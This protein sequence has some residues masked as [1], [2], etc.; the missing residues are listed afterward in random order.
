MPRI[1]VAVPV[2]NGASLLSEALANLQ[3]QTHRDFE[4]VV[5]DNASTD[6]TAEIA[7]RAAASDKRVR[8]ERR[9]TLVP[10]IENFKRALESADCDFFA[11]R[12]YDDLSAANYL[13]VLSGVLQD[14]QDIGLAVGSV[15]TLKPHKSPSPVVRRTPLVPANRA[16]AAVTLMNAAPAAWI[17]GLFRRDRLEVEFL[18]AAAVLP[19]AW[20]TDHL[21]LF[22]Y[23][24]D[25]SIAI[26]KQTYFV[27][28][29]I[30]QAGNTDWSLPTVKA[31]WDVRRR[32]HG[33][34]AERLAETDINT[35][36]KLAIRAA[37]P[38]YTSARTFRVSK[39]LGKAL[40]GR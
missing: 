8:V 40:S 24:L 7:E 34:C 3:N 18:R 39:M 23:L 6:A 16:L 1:V 37:L 35:M 32:F 27:Q 9:S 11:W 4:I 13:E 36:S 38:L 14:K 22:P 12:A 31:Q 26:S 30:K 5:C 28:R 15:H 20:A 25:G 21:T 10:A 17:Y 33:Y 19:Q 2:H 29:I